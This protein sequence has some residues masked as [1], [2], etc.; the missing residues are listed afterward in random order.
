MSYDLVVLEA[1]NPGLL[2]GSGN[3]TYLLVGA[4]GEAT[5]VDAGIGH[6][7]HLA[8]LRGALD[9][10][11]ATLTRVV[12]THAHSDHSSGAPAL[13]RQYP[14]VRFEKFP[15]PGEDSRA[16]DWRELT[17]G[18]AIQ[19]GDQS[20]AVVHTP[21]HA[22]DHIALWHAPS[23]AAFVGDLVIAGGSVVIPWSSGGDL[24]DYLRS[25]DRLI[26]LE[27]DVLYPAH[28][29]EIRNPLAML[30]AH[31]V[32]RRLR[33]KQVIDALRRGDS[34]VPAIAESIYHGL[35]PG[36]VAYASENVRAHLAKLEAEG[37]VAQSEDRWTLV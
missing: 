31:L 34:T 2:T 21:G 29:P 6:E 28:G 7:R 35:Q 18:Q 37:R 36:L 22:P 32:H 23:R 3:H 17:D 12:V 20:L 26:A 4:R 27:P 33:E 25:L 10:R 19:V 30:N 5:L 16:V 24:G 13:S 11:E 15:W 14:V 8:E 9:N 1:H